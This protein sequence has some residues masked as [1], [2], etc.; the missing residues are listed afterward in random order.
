MGVDRGKRTEGPGERRKAC[1]NN[2]LSSEKSATSSGHNIGQY[3]Q[4]IFNC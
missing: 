3:K 1:Y 2:P 4:S